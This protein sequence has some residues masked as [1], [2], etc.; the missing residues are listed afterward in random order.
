MPPSSAESPPSPIWQLQPRPVSTV[1]SR[2]RDRADPK[3][4]QAANT[5]MIGLRATVLVAGA[6]YLIALGG[7]AL[8]HVRASVLDAVPLCLGPAAFLCFY[9]RLVFPR[10]VRVAQGMEAAFIIIVLGL[11]LACLSYLGAMA[12]LPLR[13]GEMISFERQLGFDWLQAMAA[14]DRWPA[15]LKLLDAAYAT[16]TSQL[17]ATVLVLVIARRRSELDRFFITFVCAT[18]IA[19][20]ASVVVPTVGPMS[21]LAGNVEFTHLATLGRAT[22]E[23]VLALRHGT[24]KII[25]LDAINGIISFPSLHAAVAVIV[26]FTLRWNKPLFW[27]IAVFDGVM[28]IS[29]VPSGNHYVADVLGGILVAVLAILCGRQL[30]QALDRRTERIWVHARSMQ[31]PQSGIAPAE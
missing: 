9:S 12:D 8:L 1:R 5:E 18:A 28:L 2:E 11:S 15:I 29:A 16:F 10:A 25:D 17:I 20:T 14:L 22:G 24:L 27:P 3:L 23:T 31:S 6:A 7:S 30:Q 19:V 26:P 4:P 13:D 21:T